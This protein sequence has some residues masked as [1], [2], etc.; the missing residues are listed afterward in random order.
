MT[1]LSDHL[2]LLFARA[3]R[4]YCRQCGKPVQGDTP[5]TVFRR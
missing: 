5:L 4:L 3:A 1:E 2:K